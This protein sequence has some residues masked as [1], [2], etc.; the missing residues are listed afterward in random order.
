MKLVT[1]SELSSVA[2][3]LVDAFLAH[4]AHSATTAIPTPA[5]ARA[6]ATLGAVHRLMHHATNF[7]RAV[8]Y[9]WGI[10]SIA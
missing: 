2:P 6:L 10:D 5:A 4:A 1:G 9:M 3:A 8:R 7:D